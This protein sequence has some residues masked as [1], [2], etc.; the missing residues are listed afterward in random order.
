MRPKINRTDFGSITLDGKTIEY[1]IIIRLSGKTEKRKKKLSKKIFGTSHIISLEEAKFVF[2]A[3]L[4]NLIIG[5]GQYGIVTLSDEASD[6]FER[7]NVKVVLYPTPKA[8]H[9]W[10]KSK[11]QYAGLFHVTC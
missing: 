4:K 1:D 8:I 5:T 6:Y 11:G 3:G 10:N 2:E 7:K 9:E